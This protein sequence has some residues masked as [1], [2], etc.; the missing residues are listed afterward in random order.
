MHPENALYNGAKQRLIPDQRA[1]RP[2]IEY[3]AVAPPEEEA[4]R[5]NSQDI[6]WCKTN[7]YWGR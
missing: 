1:N 7:D 6:Y 4:K 3:V 2:A 5:G